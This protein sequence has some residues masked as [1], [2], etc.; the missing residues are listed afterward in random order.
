MDQNR[1]GHGQ[2]ERGNRRLPSESTPVEQRRDFATSTGTL[3]GEEMSELSDISTEILTTTRSHRDNTMMHGVTKKPATSSSF[4]ETSFH[5]PWER[6]QEMKQKP[7]KRR[8]TM[9]NKMTS[10][11]K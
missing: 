2:E 3:Y 7:R 6:V 10:N 11:L 5:L 9:T 8:R 1:E 4:S